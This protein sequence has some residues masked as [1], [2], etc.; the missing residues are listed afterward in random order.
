MCNVWSPYQ[1]AFVAIAARRHFYNAESNLSRRRLPLNMRVRVV[2][3][4]LRRWSGKARVAP[5]TLGWAN[6]KTRGPAGVDQVARLICRRDAGDAS[7]L[8]KTA[9]DGLFPKWALLLQTSPPPS[10]TSRTFPR[11][12]KCSGVVAAMRPRSAIKRHDPVSKVTA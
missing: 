5:Q 8:S 2:T 4:K 1:S 10:V 6:A 7:W 3:I 12:F 11:A 9:A